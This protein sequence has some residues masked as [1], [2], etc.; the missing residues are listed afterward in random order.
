MTIEWCQEQIAQLQSNREQL[1]ANINAINGAIETYETI[2][3][4]LKEEGG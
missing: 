3:K 4:K 2:I 1:I